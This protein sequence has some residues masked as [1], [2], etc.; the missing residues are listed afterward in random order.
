MG[1][2]SPRHLLPFRQI[3]EHSPTHRL[4]ERWSSVLV[5]AASSW[6]TTC[7][8]GALETVA[9]HALVVSVCPSHVAFDWVPLHWL[10][11]TP[12]HARQ[13]GHWHAQTNSVLYLEFAWAS[14]STYHC[15]FK[16]LNA[17]RF[18]SLLSLSLLHEDRA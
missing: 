6:L 1:S 4:E 15:E 7:A 8:Q 11:D 13:A 14:A 2:M 5:Q 12:H 18:P 16:L 9:M 17:G 3:D 10:A